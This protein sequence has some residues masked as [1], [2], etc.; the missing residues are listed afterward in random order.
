M[1]QLRLIVVVFCFLGSYLHTK[2]WIYVVLWYY[3]CQNGTSLFHI[4]QSI[5]EQEKSR[6][7]IN[8][9]TIISLTFSFLQRS[10]QDWHLVL[11]VLGLAAVD[12]VITTIS[13]LID[14]YKPRE[15][16]YT[17]MPTGENVS[18]LQFCCI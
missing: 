18:H 2:R 17:E 1:E 16:R 6:D 11:I 9:V 3:L 14:P 15:V 4:P 5:S 10:I 13:L 12:V 7:Y 8:S